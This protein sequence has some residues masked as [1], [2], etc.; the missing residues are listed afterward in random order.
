M[1]PKDLK[2]LEKHLKLAAKITDR[3]AQSQRVIATTIENCIS[4]LKRVGLEIK[5]KQPYRAPEVQSASP[6]Q[7]TRNQIKARNFAQRYG[8]DL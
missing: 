1:K 6:E 8:G 5:L 7:Q 3:L 4:E 2:L